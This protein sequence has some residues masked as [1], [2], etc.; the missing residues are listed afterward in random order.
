MNQ[1]SLR[2][3]RAQDMLQLKARVVCHPAPAG[4]SLLELLV[5]I[6]IIIIALSAVVPYVNQA[7][8]GLD[9]TR[10]SNDVVAQI[11]QARQIAIARNCNVEVRFYSY[12][13]ELNVVRYRALQSF[14]ASDDSTNSWQ[15][16]NKIQK[17]PNAICFDSGAILSPLIAGQ[18]PKAGADA[19]IKIPGVGTNYKYAAITFR[20]DGTAAPSTNSSDIFM[21]I[22]N[23]RLE[24]PGSEL[25]KNYAIIQLFPAT[26]LVRSYRP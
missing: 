4:F 3:T 22:K 14:V 21:T 16:L 10:A 24:D 18:S 13:D 26:G 2:A 1:R 20:P 12:P 15:P 11:T 9:M 23:S 6:A 5:V 25:P 7:V 17:M 19:G 8:G